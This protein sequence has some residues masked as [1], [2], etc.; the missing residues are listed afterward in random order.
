MIIGLTGSYCSGKD[1]V[2]DY[3][4]NKKG[5]SHISLS[6]IIR[7]ELQKAGIEP[8]RENLINNGKESDRKKAMVTLQK[9]LLPKLHA[10]KIT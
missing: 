8:T 10:V 6:D 2:A 9:K 4:V 7:Q 3:L 1:T 5:F